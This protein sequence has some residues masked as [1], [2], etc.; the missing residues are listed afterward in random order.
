M[1][2]LITGKD[3]LDKLPIARGAELDSYTDQHE[4][5]CLQGTRI[6]LL[7]DITDWAMSPYGKCIFW[8]NGMAGTGKSTISRTIAKSFKSEQLAVA[9]F[10]FKRGEGDRG[11]AARFFPTLSKQLATMIPDLIT[12]L[13][14]ALS[15]NPDIEA[16]SL[17][18]QFETLL[19]HPILGL[20]QVS[21]Q[22]PVVVLIIDAL[23]ECESDDDIRVILQL[24][25]RV[26]ELTSIRLRIFLTSRPELPI[27]LEFSKITNH[28]H[29][30]LHEISERVTLRDISL[31]LKERFKKIRNEKNVP[32]SW[33][34]EDEIRAL[35]E[36]S[37][38]LFIS[39]ATVCR[40]VEVNFDPVVCL[41]DLLKDQAKYATKMDKTYLPVLVR[42]L[43]G[44]EDDEA[45]I[46]QYFRQIIGLIILLAVPLSVNALSRLLKLQSRLI[47]NF[48]DSFR[49]VISLPTDE[50]LP[51]RVFHLSF[52]DFLLQ[53]ESKFFV[54]EKHT[55]QEI[56]ICCLNNMQ[57]KLKKNICNL[58]GEG[59]IRAEIDRQTIDG[60]FPAELR[61][62]CRYWAHHTAQC[63]EFSDIIA[64]ALSFLQKHFL[65]WVE[66][67][68]LLGLLSEVV[69]IINL[70]QSAIQG[71]Q[72]STMSEFLRDAKR[73]VLKNH[74]IANE[75]PLQLYCAGLVFAPKTAIIRRAFEKELPPWLYQLA[76]VNEEWR[77]EIQTLEGHSSSV[78]S[79]AFSPDGQLLASGSDDST[80]RLWD[81]VSGELK[82][83]LLAT[84][85]YNKFTLFWDPVSETLKQTFRR[86]SWSFQSVAFSPDGRLLASGSHDST[87]RLW[88]LASGVPKHILKGH[89][90]SV[91]SV[92]FSPDGRLL[93]SG[94][95]DKT[96]RLWDLAL[97]ALKQTLKGNSSS[98]LSVAFS[99][100]GRLLASGSDDKTI[101]LWDPASGV[102]KHILKGHSSSVQLVAF[103]PDGR[104][105]ASGS[106]DK[107]I[108]LWD[109]ASGALK[110]RLEGH[111]WSVQ[112]VAFSPDGRLLASGSNDKTIRLWDLASGILKQTLKGHLW[113]VQSVAFSPNGRLLASGSDDKTV[114]LWDPAVDSLK[115]TP[116]GHSSSVRSVAFSPDGRLLASGSDDKTVRLW[117]PALDSLKQ[118][119]EGHSWSV[120][121]V[122]F[123]PDGRLLA[124]GSDDSTIR[125]WDP[126]LGVPK[127]IL[128]GHSS[129]VQS[130]AFSP[131][132]RLLAS[133]SSDRT[134]RLW[135]PASG[136]LK[137]RLE[138]HSSSVLSVAFSPDCRLLASGSGDNTVRL[139]DPALGALK[140]M[141]TRDKRVSEIEF[142]QDGSY[143]RTNSGRVHF[144]YGSD[145]M[146]I[147]PYTSPK[148]TIYEQWVEVN[149]QNIL[150]LPPESR[151]I[152]SAV[153][154][155]L[156]A[157]G[158]ASGSVS[159]L[160]FNVQ[161]I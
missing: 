147:V 63:M 102:P 157:L 160:G 124:S 11:N 25:P 153:N 23:D 5:T 105:L 36:M 76:R 82:Q 34:E 64:S 119:L 114:R 131:D 31:F 70:L 17:G 40:F 73:F 74:Q 84:G 78:Q 26:Q 43:E 51:V 99:P 20:E 15:I 112:S 58:R 140:R 71:N 128:K 37:A 49:S 54:D 117:D 91:Q 87:I 142:S 27:R 89:S 88:D 28:Q 57:T 130:V 134:I 12:S 14:K 81:P 146:S 86:H 109:P 19:F 16:K 29:A 39:A 101:W 1:S 83:T 133:G 67:M 7:R 92:A 69:G 32:V 155:S 144:Q 132:G 121:S 94:S 106:S 85:S 120:Q 152:C 8:L 161:Q 24:L 151:P 55:H 18:E 35:V 42:L 38:P 136:A 113:S 96:I 104:L 116:E 126:A 138:G 47:T 115:Q 103:S 65:H 110:Q 66:A 98:V 33:P 45:Q 9:S 52:R 6:D 48:L 77:A 50:D 123:S 111:L 53:T 93:A 137:Q 141:F 22:I 95:D 118:T 90:S 159:F 68:S 56:A 60:Y 122:A 100:D 10:F 4:D 41:T 3:L 150:W 61:Y 62:S 2:D 107:T 145:T 148:I 135:D 158:H 139:W 75:A 59:I 127:H 46:L 30:A 108:R 72:H 13:T 80:V 143:I 21:S 125:L 154:G 149:G 79:V 97:G 44:Q 129:S 156:L